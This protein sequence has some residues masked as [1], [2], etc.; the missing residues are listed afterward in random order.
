MGRRKTPVKAVAYLRTS[1]KTNAGEGKDSAPRQRRKIAEFAA[2]AG[3]EVVNEF[4]DVWSGED[5]IDER[6]GFLEMLRYIAGNGART[7]LIE[8]PDRFA[9]DLAI[10][11]HGHDMLKRLGIALVPTTAPDFFTTDTPTAKLVRSMLG[12][13]AEFEKAALVAKLA[14]ARKRARDRD[15]KCEGRK[16]NAELY[17]EAVA[18]AH[19]LR[20]KPRGGKRLSLKAISDRLAAEGFRNERGEPFHPFKVSQ[21]LEAP[22]P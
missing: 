21:M 20:R 2:A 19:Q 13:V 17:P 10:Q 12:A 16:S 1:S 22:R 5:A 8:S 3:Y 11:L 14:G 9:R 15:G 7:V 18:L 4:R 6:P